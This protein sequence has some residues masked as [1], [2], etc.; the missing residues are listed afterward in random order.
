[1]KRE[2]DE[3]VGDER[4]VH[5]RKWVGKAKALRTGNVDA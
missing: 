4:K 5:N 1:M 2:V 3:R